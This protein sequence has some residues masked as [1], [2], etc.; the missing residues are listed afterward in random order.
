MTTRQLLLSTWDWDPLLI[1]GCI[2]ALFFY[3][4][5]CRLK[6][7]RKSVFFI[8][9]VVL[10][11]LALGSPIN[12]LSK[13][14]LFSAHMLQHLMLV[15]MVPP[16]IL[17]G[18]PN[19]RNH[20]DILSYVPWVK[21]PLVAWLSG[22]GA[23]WFWHVP[24][25][26]DAAASNELIHAVQTFTLLF[27]GMLFWRPIVGPRVE[28]RLS[29]LI[30]I[31]YLF[32]ACIG[33]SLLGIWITFAPVSVCPVFMS[34]TASPG[35]LAMIRDDWGLT[36]AMD[37]QIGGLLM[38]VPPCFVYLGAILVLLSRFYR[39]PRKAVPFPPKKGA[40]NE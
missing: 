30:G 6:F 3:A 17:L 8:I 18:L 1:A 4:I 22:V 36:P 16:L 7:S 40:R 14:I 39:L 9:G 25:F 31:L 2:A 5:I 32:S 37:Q 35:I 10:F 12:F 20:R 19:T 15:L 13:G 24:A 27:L 33:C 11:F 28:E 23:M 26:C 29:P 34:P 21:H 38:W